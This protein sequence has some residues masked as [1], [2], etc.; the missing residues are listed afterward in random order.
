M[1]HQRAPLEK[2]LAH[3]NIVGIHPAAKLIPIA[4]DEEFQTM[5]A[6]VAA[7]GFLHSVRIDRNN[8]LLDGGTRLQVGWALQLDPPIERIN[9]PDVLSYVLSENIIRRHLSESQRGMI[10]A[11]VATRPPRASR[12]ACTI[13]TG[14]QA[15]EMFNIG[16][17]TV[18]RAKVVRRNGVPELI[19]AVESGEI[20]LLPAEGTARLPAP[21][22]KKFLQ[23]ANGDRRGRRTRRPAK[24]PKAHKLPPLPEDAEPIE[25]QLLRRLRHFWVRTI[26]QCRGQ[27]DPARCAQIII[28]YLNAMTSGWLLHAQM[29]HS[30]KKEVVGLS[31]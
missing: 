1:N 16:T 26:V 9:P 5:C 21:E 25:E 12:D 27:L 11:S 17:S 24:R 19:Q 18:D 23:E 4:S 13:P 30:P 7:N 8:L 20:G 31:D 14:L 6:D 2:I 28:D 3:Y 15:A 22:Q 29:N 10:A